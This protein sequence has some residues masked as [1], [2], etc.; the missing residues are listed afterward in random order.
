M[1]KLKG[2]LQNLSAALQEEHQRSVEIAQQLS[3]AKATW[4]VERAELRGLIA[5][6]SYR[7]HPHSVIT[8]PKACQQ[9]HSGALQSTI[10]CIT[11]S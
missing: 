3:Q 10:E 8:S 5:Q 1:L 11:G 7:Y 9:Y 4:E 6:V 2:A